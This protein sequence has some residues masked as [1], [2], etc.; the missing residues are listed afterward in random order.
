[1]NVFFH[2]DDFGI[3]PGQSQRI[4]ECAEL[5]VLD[6]LSIMANSP[7]FEACARLL[8]AAPHHLK[9]AVHVNLVEGPCCVEPA[10]IPL[11]AGEDGVFNRSFVGLLRMSLGRDHDELRR[12]VA[13]EAA[14]QISKV[15]DRFPALAQGL[16]V[17]GHQHFQ[18]IPAV[19]EG[20]LDAVWKGGYALEY[21]RVPVEPVRAFMR[22]DVLFSIRPVNWIKRLV[23]GW[24]WG[25]DRRLARSLVGSGHPRS[26]DGRSALFC[27]VLFSGEMSA[28]RVCAV[29]PAY[30]S[31]ARRRGLDIE[32]LFHPG[33]EP[34]AASCLNPKMEDFVAFYQSSGR[35]VEHD[36]LM[37][38][39]L[40]PPGPDGLPTLHFE[41]SCA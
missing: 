39:R 40:D 36:A 22:S 6:S 25:R 12:Q 35:G 37:G 17:D 10:S 26:C 30:A 20:I 29:F 16:R 24:C 11:L 13:L 3:N 34:D 7:H 19:F 21:L 28:E 18:L 9:R 38:L 27:G 31:L 41:G 1:M 32:L 5:G 2:A 15:T 8:D 33:G 4:L 14:A 23:L